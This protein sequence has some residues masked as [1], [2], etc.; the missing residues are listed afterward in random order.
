MLCDNITEEECLKLNLFGDK[1]RK[2]QDLNDIKQGDIG[3]LLNLDSDELIGVFRSSS[4]PKLHIE[5]DAWNG[6]FAAQVRVEPIGNLQRI[7]DAAFIMQKAGVTMRQLNLGALVPYSPVYGR[8]VGEKIL[9]H[10][11]DM[12]K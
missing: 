9:A 12:T 7:K 3:F 5:P 2:L 11:G 1:A 6:R 8:D 10:F 4:E